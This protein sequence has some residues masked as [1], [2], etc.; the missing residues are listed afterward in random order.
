MCDGHPDGG[1]DDQEKG[2]KIK[3]DVDNFEHVHLEVGTP[4]LVFLETIEEISTFQIDSI[5]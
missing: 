1:I 4:C 5:V 2:D 3:W